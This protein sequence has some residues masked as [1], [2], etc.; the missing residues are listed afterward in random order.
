MRR[1]LP[2]LLLLSL[3][4]SAIAGRG[5]VTTPRAFID[6]AA[7]DAIAA[8]AMSAGV[9]GL[10]ITVRKGNTVFTRAY[11]ELN[12]ATHVPARVDSVYQVGSV[13]KQF[14][15]AAI[16]R[17]AEEGK[18]SIDDRARKYLPELGPAFDAITIRHLLNHT[19]GVRDY[20]EQLGDAYTPKTQQEI[21]ALITVGPPLYTPGVAF[22]YSNSGYFLLGMI[23]ER[24]SA[25]SY[26]QYLRDAFFVPL[27]L[28]ATSYCG[29]NGASPDGYGRIFGTAVVPAPAA[30]MSLVFA[31]GA[32]CST[33]LDL[34][35]WNEAL[36]SGR[37][38]SRDSYERMITESV[39]MSPTAKYGYALIID[40]LDGRRRI[41]HNGA[42]LGFESQLAWFPDEQLTIAVL[43]NL[44][45][46][47]R[48]FALEIGESVARLFP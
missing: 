48:D 23:I 16:L 12:L 45:D 37:A 7:I 29:T 22:T 42:I 13:T 40:R 19:S 27:G 30:D 2:L 47:R 1:L 44:I 25:K 3:T 32:V 38:I 35:R 39:A 17:L 18:L 36:A 14:T 9:P 34:V 41:W 4:P 15:A 10:T 21:L 28:S 33:T 6:T 24:V 5:R 20:N 43:L 26:A 8:K 31:A 11:G 46:V